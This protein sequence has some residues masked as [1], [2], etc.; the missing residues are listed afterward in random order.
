MYADGLRAAD[1]I[2]TDRMGHLHPGHRAQERAR[3]M[4]GR[5]HPDRGIGELSRR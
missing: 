5:A 3:E 4:L 2:E 1:E